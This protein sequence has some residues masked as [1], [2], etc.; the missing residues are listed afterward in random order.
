MSSGRQA[1]AA[2]TVG[3]I[4]IRREKLTAQVDEPHAVGVVLAF[5]SVWAAVIDSADL[6]RI[7][8]NTGRLIGRL[9]LGGNPVRASVG[10]GS[11][12]V[13]DDNGRVLRVR[14]TS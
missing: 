3:Q 8:G 14:P 7:D 13:N 4:D 9:H 2:R 6:D 5:G 11:I 10:F 1:A 12:W